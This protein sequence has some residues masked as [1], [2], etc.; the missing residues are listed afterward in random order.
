MNVQFTLN[1]GNQSE[2][3]QITDQH[4]Y[5]VID[6]VV[7][8]PDEELPANIYKNI[9]TAKMYALVEFEKIELDSSSL[10][11]SRK[12]FTSETRYDAQMQISTKLCNRY[13]YHNVIDGRRLL[14]QGY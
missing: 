12:A 10:H 2:N 8:L 5:K 9:A 1:V 7:V 13:L 11:S 3:G 6:K 14:T 4:L